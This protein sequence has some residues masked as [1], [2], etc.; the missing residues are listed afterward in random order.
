[1]AFLPS[2]THVQDFGF[3]SFAFKIDFPLPLDP[4]FR[5]LAKLIK[6]VELSI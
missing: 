2:P 1:M 5:K 4:L 6:Q 3:S